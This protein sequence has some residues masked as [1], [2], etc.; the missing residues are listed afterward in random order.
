MNEVDEWEL[1]DLRIDPDETVNRYHFRESQEVV[2]GLKR[3]LDRLRTELGDGP[4]ARSGVPASQELNSQGALGPMLPA[5]KTSPAS[6]PPA[7]PRN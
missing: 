7:L 2:A 6:R 5:A 4:N 3:E 1:L